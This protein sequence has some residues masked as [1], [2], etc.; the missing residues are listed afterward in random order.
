MAPHALTPEEWVAR[1]MP[2]MATAPK[3]IFFTDFDGTVTKTDSN[4]YMTDNLGYGRENRLKGNEDI[5]D[6]TRTFRDAFQEMLDS[7]NTPFPEC[8]EILKREIELDPHFKEFYAWARENNVPVVVLSGGMEQVIR[9]ML[10]NFLGAEEASAIQIVSNYHGPKT[11]GV[12]LD[13]PA[14]WKI[15]FRH[16]E[17]G[18]GH[19]KSRAIKPY[20]ALSDAER[21][22][23][24]YAGDGV[25]DLSAAR[26]TDLL[27]A[28]EGRD[29]VSWCVRENVPF[30]TFQTWRE[31]LDG[32]KQIMAGEQSVAEIALQGHAK[33]L[34]EQQA[35]Q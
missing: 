16:P 8:I 1:D 34:A 17:S 3:M 15:M 24:L 32:C 5:L 31:I 28:K 14:G 27:F 11:E 6:G 18:F 30:T 4:D 7:V 2:A 21:P 26:E 29:L 20:A 19:D 23:M 22:V 10:D 12:D 25:S 13:G 33:F 35:K 9:A